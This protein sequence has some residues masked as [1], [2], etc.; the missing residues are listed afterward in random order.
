MQWILN[1]FARLWWSFED[2]TGREDWVR[3]IYRSNEP[4]ITRYYLCSTRWIDDLKL[5]YRYPRLHK[6]LYKVSFRL[7]LHH[8]HQSD[9]DGHHDHP[10]PWASWVLSGGYWEDT[11]AGARW[12]WPGHLRFRSAKS[13]HRLILDPNTRK[14]VWTLFLM[15]PREREWGFVG[16]NGEWVPWFQHHGLTAPKS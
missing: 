12:R 1:R 11:P 3:V 5:L 13:L 2:R 6:M 9:S 16:R 4:L 7:V 15:G 14:E 8:M 10:W